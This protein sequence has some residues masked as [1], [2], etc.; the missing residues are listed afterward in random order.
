MSRID[1][2]EGVPFLLKMTPVQRVYQEVEVEDDEGNVDIVKMQATKEF[3]DRFNGLVW[4]LLSRCIDRASKDDRRTLWPE[5]VPTV[6]EV[7]PE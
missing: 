7:P 5:D 1:P 6:E 3:K 4:S 2:E